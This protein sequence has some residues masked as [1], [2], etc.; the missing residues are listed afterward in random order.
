MRHNYNEQSRKCEIPLYPPSEK[1]GEDKL[2]NDRG[3]MTVGVMAIFITG[4]I[5]VLDAVNTAKKINIGL[6]GIE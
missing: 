2:A 5:S 4:L 1:L 6:N 3:L